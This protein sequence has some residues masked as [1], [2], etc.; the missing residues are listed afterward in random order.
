MLDALVERHFV[1]LG[2]RAVSV[3]IDARLGEQSEVDE[4]KKWMIIPAGHGVCSRR[5]A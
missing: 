1:G 4:G 5:G 3:R 2:V